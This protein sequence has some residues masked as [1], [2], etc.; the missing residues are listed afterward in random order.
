MERHRISLITGSV[1][2][3]LLGMVGKAGQ[4]GFRGLSNQAV[5]SVVSKFLSEACLVNKH[6]QTATA[7]KGCIF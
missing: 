2:L 1:R 3:L 7:R 4:P 5:L 6:S